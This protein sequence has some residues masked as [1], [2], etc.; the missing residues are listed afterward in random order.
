M[1]HRKNINNRRVHMAAAKK[2]AKKPAAKKPAKT[3]KKGCGC[4]K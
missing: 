1:L 4:K 2:T 3:A